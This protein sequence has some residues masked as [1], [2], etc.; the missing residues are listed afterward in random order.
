VLAIQTT[1]SSARFDRALAYLESDKLDA[2]RRRFK[3]VAASVYQLVQVAYGLGE[4][5]WRQH[6]TNEAIRNFKLYLANANTNTPRPPT[7]FN[8][9]AN[10]KAIHPETRPMRV[11]HTSSPGWSS[12]AH[13]KTPSPPCSGLRQKPGVEVHLLSGPTTGPEGSLETELADTPGILTRVPELVRPIHP[14]KDWLALRRLVKSCANKSLTSC[15]PTAAR[16]EFSAGLAARRAG[17]AGDPPPH[18]WPI[19]RPVPGDL[20]PTGCLPLPNV[21]PPE[22]PRISSAPPRP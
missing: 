1:N 22:L 9:S 15:T 7:S 3:N 19:L 2:A 8:G 16:L 12:A 20:W 5:A 4:I 18:S 11:T 6:E 13:R 10:S 14:L 21:T 17:R